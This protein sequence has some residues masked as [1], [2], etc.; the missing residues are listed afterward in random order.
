MATQSDLRAAENA[1][2]IKQLA[3]ELGFSYCG[4]SQADFLN[5]A[6]PRLEA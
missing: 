2:L 3:L 5:D 6:A 4:I 1:Q